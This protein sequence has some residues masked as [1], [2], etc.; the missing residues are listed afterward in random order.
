MSKPKLD[1][2][3]KLISTATS[4]VFQRHQY[5]VDKRIDNLI[6]EFDVNDNYMEIQSDMIAIWTD[7]TL[8]SQS[9]EG[10]ELDLVSLEFIAL[11]LDFTH[12][13]ATSYFECF[14]PKNP[15]G[16]QLLTDMFTEINAVIFCAKLIS[17]FQN[18]W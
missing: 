18:S 6:Y 1:E 2:Y 8:V 13:V 3:I 7:L 9:V 10:N 5:V 16:E 17:N 4:L 14:E 15:E 11:Q 12:C